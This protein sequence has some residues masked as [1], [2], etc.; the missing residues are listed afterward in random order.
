[1]SCQIT[2]S[3]QVLPSPQ[4]IQKSQNLSY[5]KYARGLATGAV[6]VGGVVASALAINSYMRTE[7]P[8]VP[9]NIFEGQDVKKAAIIGGLGGSLTLGGITA[10]HTLYEYRRGIPHDYV[11]QVGLVFL[12][13]LTGIWPGIMTSISILGITRCFPIHEEQK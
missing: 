10:A 5:S 3:P 6:V 12:G 4:T 7:M 9:N 2:Q 8:I 1:M 13:A 11:Q